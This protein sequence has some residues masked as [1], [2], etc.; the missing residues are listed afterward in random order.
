MYFMEKKAQAGT[1]EAVTA[2]QSNHLFKWIN[3]NVLCI[4]SSISYKSQKL[5]CVY[6][7]FKSLLSSAKYFYLNHGHGI[8]FKIKGRFWNIPTISPFVIRNTD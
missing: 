3:Q 5:A 4:K 7:Y 1:S 8:S 2:K 6:Q